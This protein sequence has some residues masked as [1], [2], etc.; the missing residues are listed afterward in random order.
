MTKRERLHH[1]IPLTFHFD[2]FSSLS[3][4]QYHPAQDVLNSAQS[5]AMVSDLVTHELDYLLTQLKANPLIN[6]QEDW[7][8][9]TIFIGANDLC[10][11]CGN[12]SYLQPGM[13]EI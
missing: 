3:T 1:F 2:L 8:L 10:S 11:S 6:M 12:Q 4:F 9:L 13:W 7:K 5:G